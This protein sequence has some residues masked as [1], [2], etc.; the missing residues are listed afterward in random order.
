MKLRAGFSFL[1]PSWLKIITLAVLE[2]LFTLA[3]TLLGYEW[4]V[5]FFSPGML[6][7]E[8]MVDVTNTSMINL[9]FHG[10]VSNVIGFVYLYLLTCIIISLYY[11]VRSK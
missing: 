3:Y 11:K 9:A 4:W 1:N 2:F 10:A 8:A 7:L 6:Y 5:Y